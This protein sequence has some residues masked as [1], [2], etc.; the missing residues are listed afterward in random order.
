VIGLNFIY[1][2]EEHNQRIIMDDYLN[3]AKVR[4]IEHLIYIGVPARRMGFQEYPENYAN[5]EA[6]RDFFTDLNI[7]SALFCECDITFLDLARIR[8][9]LIMG[10]N[11][12][13]LVVEL[14]S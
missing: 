6:A 4:F 14:I 9:E 1:I 7:P 10:A 11:W 5:F 8:R 3:Q 12:H 13:S 2:L